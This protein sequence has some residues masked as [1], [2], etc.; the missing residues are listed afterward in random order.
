MNETLTDAALISTSTAA[1]AAIGSCVCPGVGS[2]VGAGIGAI[3][4]GTAVIIRVI[5]S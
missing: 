5:K 4:G 1:G 2:A 3:V